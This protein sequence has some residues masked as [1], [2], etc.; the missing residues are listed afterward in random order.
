MVERLTV[1][2]TFERNDGVFVSLVRFGEPSNYRHKYY[3][4]YHRK[5]I[6]ASTTF[7]GWH[8]P[9]DISYSYAN[10]QKQFKLLTKTEVNFRFS[11]D[12]G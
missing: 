6:E 7:Y 1:L 10:A 4:F 11:D 2:K 5:P 12:H 3:A 8:D 9:S